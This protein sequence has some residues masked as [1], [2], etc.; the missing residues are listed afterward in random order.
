MP[1]AIVLI[2]RWPFIESFR[3]VLCQF[4]RMSLTPIEIPVRI[5]RRPYDLKMH[6]HHRGFSVL[7]VQS[8][9]PRL[10]IE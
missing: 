6:H 1:K 2:S 7:S 5:A 9:Y 8:K 4:Y 3:D 10:C